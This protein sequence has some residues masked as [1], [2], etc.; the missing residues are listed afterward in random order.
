MSKKIQFFAS[1]NIGQGIKKATSAC[2]LLLVAFL[3]ED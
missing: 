1:K 2:I 3:F